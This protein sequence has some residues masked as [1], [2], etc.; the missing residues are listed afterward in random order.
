MLEVQPKS[1]TGLAQ[2][3]RS[4]APLIAAGLSAHA[5]IVGLTELVLP[6]PLLT[7]L[8]ATLVFAAV[9]IVCTPNQGAVVRSAS[10]PAFLPLQAQGL[11]AAGIAASV[12]LIDRLFGTGTAFY[13]EPFVPW[14]IEIAIFGSFAVGIL[15]TMPPVGRLEWTIHPITMFA[16]LWIAPFYGFFSAPLFL[17]ISLNNMCPDR[18]MTSVVLAALGILAGG[19]I[20]HGVARWISNRPSSRAD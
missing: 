7:A 17:G 13:C 5:V 14:R 1:W 9:S 11:A 20:G 4:A 10:Q 8:V 19:Q 16:F 3:A 15:T 18:S 6:A 2:A 12:W